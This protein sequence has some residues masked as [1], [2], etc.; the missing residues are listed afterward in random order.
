MG[1]SIESKISEEKEMSNT[2]HMSSEIDE[3]VSIEKEESS[4]DN[5]DD[6]EVTDKDAVKTETSDVKP[7]SK[8]FISSFFGT[9][10]G[11]FYGSKKAEDS[12]NE[13]PPV[14]EHVPREFQMQPQEA[15]TSS[16]NDGKKQTIDLK[17]ESEI[18]LEESEDIQNSE[19]E[20][21]LNTIDESPEIIDNTESQSNDATESNKKDKKEQLDEMKTLTIESVNEEESD[22]KHISVDNSNTTDLLTSRKEDESAISISEDKEMK[23]N[24]ASSEDK[25]DSPKQPNDEENKSESKSP[26]SM[27]TDDKVPDVAEQEESTI[28]PSKL[29]ESVL[30]DEKVLDV[31]EQEDIDIAMD[32]KE[33]MSEKDWKKSVE[34]ADA[35]K[36][37]FET[38]D[39]LKTTD[40]KKLLIEEDFEQEVKEKETIDLFSPTTEKKEIEENLMTTQEESKKAE[41]TTATKKE[42]VLTE[43]DDSQQS[44]ENLV[45]PEIKNTNVQENDI[46][47]K[48]QDSQAQDEKQQ[49]GNALKMD[50]HHEQV[51]VNDQNGHEDISVL[52]SQ[53]L[54]YK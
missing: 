4:A 18:I 53:E 12:N 48:T 43:K 24:Q 11:Y 22:P 40:S 45:V 19:N 7:Q 33:P 47:I 32:K 35:T 5:N 39:S 26:D 29:S 42:F 31:A 23:E 49:N 51:K 14:T 10:G 46:K 44:K 8:G 38:L 34:T 28:I 50:E 41:I 15:N 6:L 13:K 36:P 25:D 17:N 52:N 21:E 20:M 54:K 30:T 1:S 3:K 2:E 9:V 16:S 37:E 27:S